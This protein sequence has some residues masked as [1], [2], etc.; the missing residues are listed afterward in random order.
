MKKFIPFLAATFCT[1]LAFGLMSATIGGYSQQLIHFNGIGAELV[2]LSLTFALTVVGIAWMVQEFGGIIHQ[3]SRNDLAF[4]HSLQG[5]SQSHIQDIELQ[6][7][8]WEQEQR[9]LREINR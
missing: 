8:R 9:I 1:F 2:F 3:Q 4:S 7:D 6:A 5:T